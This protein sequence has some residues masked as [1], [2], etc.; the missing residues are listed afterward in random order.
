DTR[1]DR[2]PVMEESR[3]AGTV[4]TEAVPLPARLKRGAQMLGALWR[5]NQ[6]CTFGWGVAGHESLPIVCDCQTET[7]FCK[8]KRQWIALALE[9]GVEFV[10]G[11][12]GAVFMMTASQWDET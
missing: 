11:E 4:T 10:L 7:R 12:F 1:F 8:G 5:S 3:G 6:R 9:A 2:G